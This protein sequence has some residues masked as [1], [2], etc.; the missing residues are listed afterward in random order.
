MD[1]LP[2][3]EFL[4]RKWWAYPLDIL[5]MG[6]YRVYQTLQYSSCVSKTTSKDYERL[7]AGLKE[8]TEGRNV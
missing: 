2:C 4:E 6:G 8:G 5:S 1:K 3:S 7:I